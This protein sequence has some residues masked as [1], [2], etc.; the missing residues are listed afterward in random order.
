[1]TFLLPLALVALLVVPVIYLMHFLRGSRRRVRVP[2][3]FLWADLP[4]IPA[5]QTRR[6][7]PPFSLLLVL[8]L[9]AGAVAAL[10]LARP[11]SPSDPPLH[12]ALVLDASGSMLATDVSP[13]R[14]DAARARALDRLGGLKSTDVVSVVRAGAEATLLATGPRDSVRSALESAQAASGTAAVREAVA[15]ASSQVQTTPDRRGQIVLLTDLAFAPLEPVGVLAA[16]VEIVAVGGGS[17]NQAVSALQVRMDPSGRAQTAF[18]DLANEAEHAVRVPMRITGD[19][20][21]LDQRDIDLPAR[22]HVRLSVPLPTDVRRIGV[23]LLGKD[24]LPQDDTAEAIAPGGPPR[25]VLLS[26]RAGASLRRALEAMPFV[27]L[28]VGE[29]TAAPADLTVL[30]ATLPSQLPQ[31]PLLLVDPPASSARLLG[32]GLG[33]GA[34]VEQTH[35]L[36]QG[37]DL[38]ALQIENPSVGGVPGWAKVVFGTLQ[39]PLV[40]EGRLEG[41]PTVALTFD[42]SV[43]GLDKSLAFPLLISNATSYLLAQAEAPAAAQTPSFDRSESDIA[44]RQAP[45]FASAAQPDPS[46]GNSERWPWLVAAVVVILSLEWLVFARRG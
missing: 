37:L 4:R 41:R 32:V 38:G 9:L 5:G 13:S 20:A 21:P 17:E 10:A 25:E 22:G 29:P 35:P 14:F 16:P 30:E 12:L 31:G 2:A 11:V 18:V 46:A 3:L 26:G 23:R 45:S 36:L 39:G 24:A 33:S 1:M 34:R 19:D 28:R 15:L 6:R 44:P 27:R 7:W 43:S 8:Q 40:L 42:P